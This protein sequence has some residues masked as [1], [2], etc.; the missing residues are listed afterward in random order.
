MY[1]PQTRAAFRRS[2]VYKDRVRKK[3]RCVRIGYANDCHVDVVP[4]LVL[5]DGRQVI[6]N[7][8]ANEFED[9]NRRGSPTG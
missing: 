2:S 7:Y 8:E 1:L 4:Y 3:N 6:V 9:T 5:A